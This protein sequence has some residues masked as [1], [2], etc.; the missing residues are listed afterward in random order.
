MSDFVTSLIR[1]WVPMLVG[2][3][4]SYFVT[5]GIELDAETQAGIIVGMTGLFQAVYYLI[6]RLVEKKF[7][8]A[9]GLLLGSSAKPMYIESNK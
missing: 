8:E 9:G 1:T 3:I 4:A 2:A 7:P 5:L 6:V